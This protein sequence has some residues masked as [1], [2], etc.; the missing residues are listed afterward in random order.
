[1]LSY[2][3][4]KHK[5]GAHIMQFHTIP[6]FIDKF[7]YCTLIC[8]YVSFFRQIRL[9]V[10]KRKKVMARHF[11]FLLKV[12]IC[13]HRKKPQLITFHLIY[14]LLFLNSFF[15]KIK[16]LQFSLKH[17]Y[18]SHGMCVLWEYKWFSKIRGEMGWKYRKYKIMSCSLKMHRIKPRCC[19]SFIVPNL[20]NFLQN[21][22][23]SKRQRE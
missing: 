14:N 11:K 22:I 8:Y 9:G 3:W 23:Y 20:K 10:Y 1:M 12:F 5:N 4:G 15:N 21:R 7:I 17:T 16:Y 19:V 2:W 13:C 6:F 18:E